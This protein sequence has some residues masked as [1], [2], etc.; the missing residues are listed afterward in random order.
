MVKCPK[1]KKEIDHL[2]HYTSGEMYFILDTDENYEEV[3]FQADGKVNEYECP[4]CQKVI[5][6]DPYKAEKF[7][8]KKK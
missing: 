7:M 5:F 1:C 4:E 3:E 8:G 2:K 6:T